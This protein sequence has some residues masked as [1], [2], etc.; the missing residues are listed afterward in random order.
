MGAFETLPKLLVAQDAAKRRFVFSL[1]LDGKFDVLLHPARPAL[2]KFVDG[3]P[4]A[5][6]FP[7]FPRDGTLR[8]T[9]IEM[10]QKTLIPRFETR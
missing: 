2:L 9:L 7:F 6:P 5:P 10:F 8:T 4:P 3:A 1:Q